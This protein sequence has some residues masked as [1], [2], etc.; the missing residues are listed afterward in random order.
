MNPVRIVR[1]ARYPGL[2]AAGKATKQ[3]KS[4]ISSSKAAAAA[5]AA[6]VTMLAPGEQGYV[7]PGDS[8]QL[9]GFRKKENA[10]WS[11]VLHP[12]P[13][14]CASIPAKGVA[15]SSSI[16]AVATAVK[17]APGMSGTE[18]KTK[19]PGADKTSTP[20]TNARRQAA[21]TSTAT[22]RAPS[23]PD[24]SKPFGATSAVTRGVWKDT[25]ATAGPTG[26]PPLVPSEPVAAARKAS[27]SAVSGIPST[28]ADAV[29]ARGKQGPA[30][31][32]KSEGSGGGLSASDT[33]RDG[34]SPGEG[35]TVKKKLHMGSSARGG[36]SNLVSMSPSQGQSPA[37]V[38]VTPPSTSGGSAE[39]TPSKRTR[40]QVE[41]DE[42]RGSSLDS[43]PAKL[44]RQAA[45][46]Q[47]TD[48]DSSAA[49][50]PRERAA[51]LTRHDAG[52]T[53]EAGTVTVTDERWK[54]G[55]IV[56]LEARTSKGENK[57]G[58]VARVVSVFDDNTYRVKLTLGDY[59]LPLCL[60]VC[61]SV[62]LSLFLSLC[63]AFDVNRVCLAA[64]LDSKRHLFHESCR[65]SIVVLHMR[66]GQPCL[67]DAV[68]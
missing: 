52:G 14:G 26:Y 61:P 42:T 27:A 37:A 50:T 33:G 7:Y 54:A 20:S 32:S 63:D 23:T 35:D 65:S 39:L 51:R 60:S 4:A 13:P 1:W 5:A 57:L 28:P 47:S 8:L 67:R 59:A 24:S 21:A 44:P 38:A 11:Y 2:E 62:R 25:A 22:A 45:A 34:A 17:R 41:K 9:D 58:G 53:G 16:A 12:L 6:A 49:V 55:D 31:G 29:L 66:A 15:A 19:T 36:G 48:D 46:P 68:L 56:E 3:G 43:P 10:I 30:V 18:S 40:A 64:P